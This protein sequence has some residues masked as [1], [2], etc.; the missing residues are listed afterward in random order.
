MDQDPNKLTYT[1]PPKKLFSSKKIIA[2]VVYLILL[3][4]LPLFVYISQQPQDIRQE[5][6]E[7]ASLLPISPFPVARSTIEN[8]MLS[9]WSG[10]ITAR[11]VKKTPYVITLAAVSI[12]K[13]ESGKATANDISREQAYAVIFESPKS[14]IFKTSN[15][16]EE[17]G[18]S[19]LFDGDIVKG[20]VEFVNIS[21]KWQR[22]I[23]ALAIQTDIPKSVSYKEPVLYN[24]APDLYTLITQTSPDLLYANAEGSIESKAADSFVIAKDGNKLTLFVEEDQGITTFNDGSEV[25]PLNPAEPHFV[26]LKVG[27][28]VKGGVSIFVS[29]QSALGITP[30]RV[31]GDIVAHYMTIE[32]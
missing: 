3:V 23:A 22:I 6:S 16:Q 4:G 26:D 31:Q 32:E 17:L 30:I 9:E 29:S 19:A 10:Q 13:N 7:P 8:S 20:T 5:A 27:Q 14:K 15:P 1:Q 25:N 12:E 18:F 28:T 11:V 24:D 2:I 21:G